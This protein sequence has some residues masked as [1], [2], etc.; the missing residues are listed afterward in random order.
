MRQAPIRAGALLLALALAASCSADDADAQAAATTSQARTQQ[1]TTPAAPTAPTPTA[2]PVEFTAC[3]S[4]G[5]EVTPGTNEISRV[6]L[7][8]GEMTIEH[9]RGYTWQLQ[10]TDVSEPRLVGTW[11]HSNAS[12]VYTLPGG[13][14]G[15]NFGPVTNRI[16]NDEG[17]WQ[18]SFQVVG[19][20]DD[21]GSGGWTV[22]MDGE[23]AYEGLTAVAV[24][25]SGA[26]PNMR[27]YIIDHSLPPP[28]L[29]DTG[30]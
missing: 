20:P 15:P 14:A 17:A 4:A 24:K 9:S 13:L 23:G 27:G 26:C 12:D 29:P 1:S 6:A 3:V 30:R 18:G 7:P 28:P 21:V 19:F 11:Y 25:H 10:V 8:D 5:P 16:E 22:A 2:V